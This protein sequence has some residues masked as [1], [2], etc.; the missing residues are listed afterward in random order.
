MSAEGLPF[1]DYFAAAWRAKVETGFWQFMPLS[2]KMLTTAHYFFKKYILFR[3]F[4]IC[5][6]LSHSGR[7][8]TKKNF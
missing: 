7:F 2:K 4:Y 8:F 1:L 5:G 3:S 6:L